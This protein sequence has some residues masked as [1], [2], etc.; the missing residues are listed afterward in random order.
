MVIF[1]VEGNDRKGVSGVEGVGSVS[2]VAVALYAAGRALKA[3]PLQKVTASSI[4]DVSDNI[5]GRSVG[6]QIAVAAMRCA[7]R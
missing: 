1:G 6:R 7:L 4:V 3:S 2:R 5:G